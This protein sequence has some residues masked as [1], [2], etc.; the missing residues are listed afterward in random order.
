VIYLNK[1]DIHAA[2]DV[3]E[4]VDVIE[5][6]MVLYEEGRCYMPKRMHVDYDG[7]TL[8]LMPCFTESA[9]ATKL[10][11]LFPDNPARG[12]PVLTGLVVL[13]DIGTGEPLAVLEGS[14][15]TAM[16]TAAVAS[17]SIRHL[18]SD[19]ARSVGVIGAGVQ[20]Y[21]Q[22]WIA[23]A[24]KGLSEVHIFDVHSERARALSEELADVLPGVSIQATATVE[25]LLDKSDTVITATISLE[26]VLPDEP[27]LLRGKHF[28]GIGSYKPEMREFPKAIFG[29]IDKVFIDTD[30]AMGEAG[31]LIVPIRERWI[32]KEQVV[33]FGRFLKDGA[34]ASGSVKET[35]FFKSVGMAMFDVCAS[36]LI[37]E[38]AV[39]K[40]LGQEMKS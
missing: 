15:L 8:L 11:T 34:A 22:A 28:V 39:E 29:L 24:S 13:N 5:Q 16:R 23:C 27:E 37:Y 33:T 31:D 36:Q 26:P 38:K 18:V 20:G 32:H 3:N 35:T 6:S 30:H 10:V 17:V 4:I 7:D 9:F 21:Y 2:L 14:T 1:Q 40:G 19:D 12:L 25:E